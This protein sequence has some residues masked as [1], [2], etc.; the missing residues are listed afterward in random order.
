MKIAVDTAGVE[1]GSRTVVEGALAAWR[2]SVSLGDPIEPVLY[3]SEEEIRSVLNEL[4]ESEK[5]LAIVHAPDII[6][7]QDHPRDILSSKQSSS[8]LQAVKHLAVGMVSAF[9]S[10]GNTGAVVGVCRT[11]LGR[12]RWINKPALSVPL[13]RKNRIG[14]LLDVGATA[15][16]KANH[17]VQYAAMGAAFSEQ[18]HHIPNPRIGLLNIGE[19][20]HKGDEL[21][22]DTFRLLSRSPLNFI[23]NIEGGDIFDD[24]A[25]VIVTSGFVGNIL[26]KFIESIPSILF[27]RVGNY[28]WVQSLRES[29]ADLD[30]T[31]WGGA[32]LLGVNGTV[33]IGH[34]RSQVKAITQALLWAQKMVRA[35]LTLV[36]RDRVFRTRRALWLSNPFSRG[37]IGDEDDEQ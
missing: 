20:S 28:P 2:R 22:R 3:G 19:E 18:V 31:H 5:N 7:M 9:V 33:V 34:G 17:L 16:P 6:T 13:P 1:P 4:G 21:T 15:D 12:V 26:L 36:L 23:G 32:T 14:L 27:E 35:N 37:E 11:Y 10:M 29:F 24:R 25:D 8:I 30:Y